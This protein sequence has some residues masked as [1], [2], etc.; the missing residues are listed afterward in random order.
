MGE[1]LEIRLDL[2]TALQRDLNRA[3]A[4]GADLTRPMKEIAV[5]LEAVV[6]RRFETETGPGGV[7]WKI[8]ERKQRDPSA[9]ILFLHGDLQSAIHADSGS[10]FAEIGVERSFGAAVYARI[11]QFGGVIRPVVKK[12]L[13]FG[14]RI[15][16]QVTIPARPYLGFDEEDRLEVETILGSFLH[17]LLPGGEGVA[18]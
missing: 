18:A 5:H 15:L 4:G 11:Q 3:I 12:A 13:S 9:H 1:P 2:G 14:G 7:P 17:D 10:D 16:A 6:A 8:T